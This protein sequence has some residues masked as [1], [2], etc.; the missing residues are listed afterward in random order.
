MRLPAFRSAVTLSHAVVETLRICAP[1]VLEATVGRGAP[2]SVYDARLRS[3]SARLLAHAGVRVSVEGLEHLG[4]G[5]EVFLVMSNHQSHYDVPVLF[6]ALPLQLRMIAKQELFRV[7]IWGEAMRT[8]GFV[9]ID[10]RDRARAI[11]SLALA[12][13]RMV[14]EGIS[15]WIAPEGT[16]SR[17]GRLGP[18][19]SGGFH[20]ALDAGLR[21]LP[22]TIV[23]TFDV[24]RAG[25]RALGGRNEVRVV[26]H[27]PIDPRDYG[28]ERRN[29]LTDAVRATIASAL[30]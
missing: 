24:L 12:K 26:V 10:R 29:E 27:A 20:L 11:E 25:G 13:R 2:H 21:V 17:D 22:V 16:R 19:K 14:E 4:D 28:H 15:I 9:A 1:T 18:F 30:P 7:P 23:G 5:R 3:W 8:S 6:Q